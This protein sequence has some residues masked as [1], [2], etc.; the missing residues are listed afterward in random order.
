MNFKDMQIFF[1]RGNLKNTK[2]KKGSMYGD[3]DTYI[4]N[5]MEKNTQKTLCVFRDNIS[6]MSYENTDDNGDDK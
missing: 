3:N 4:I 6:L 1:R 5:Y 2:V